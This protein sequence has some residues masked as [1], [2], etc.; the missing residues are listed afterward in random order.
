MEDK[1]KLLDNLIRMLKEANEMQLRL[2]TI[3]AREILRK[4]T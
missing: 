4:R 3:A 2:L 1:V